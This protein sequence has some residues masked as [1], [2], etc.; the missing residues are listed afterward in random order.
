MPEPSSGGLPTV[1]VVVVN[2]RGVRDTITCLRSLRD[3]LDYP[4]DRLEIICVDNASGDGSVERLRDEMP[5]VTLVESPENLGFAGGCNLGARQ[6]TGQVLA[7]LNNDARPDAE[8]V[9]AAVAVF[10][11][12]PTVGA[13]ASKV[14]D[15][16]GELIDFVDG[17]LTWFG[18]GYKRHAGQRDDGSHEVA[19]DVLFGT[20]SALFVR[21]ELFA[22][23]GGFDE[24][25]FMFYED[26]DLGWRLNLRGWRVRYEPTSVTYHRHH[27]SMGSVDS[28]REYY[29]LER[30]ALA[31]L[32]KNLEDET[33][34][35]VLPAALALAVRRSTARGDIDPTQLEITRR[36][37]DRGADAEPV[38]VS[39][40][41]LAGFLA[42]DQFV[43]LLP[44][45]A[46]SR[47]V[48][49]ESRVRSDGDIVPLMRKALEPAYP[50]PR[51]LAAHETL[52]RAFGLDEAFGRPRR[53]LVVTGDA[54]AERM[55]GPAIRAWHM[56]EALSTEH[57]V[58]LVSVNNH[59]EPPEAGFPVV[60]ARPRDLGTHIAWSDIVVVQGHIMEM[61]PELKDPSSGK[62][63]V[64][65]VYDPMH[66]EYL[67]QGKD[68]DDERRA[69]DLDGVT[70]V[71]NTQ[72]M[73]GDFFLCASE[74]QRHFWLGHL[75][76]LGRLSPGMY[77]SDPTVRSLLS[78]VPFGLPAARPRRTAPAIRDVVP[79]IGQRERIV[80][81]AGGVY[82]WFDPLTLVQAIDKLRREEDGVRLVF[83][84]MQH[85]NPD[86][87]E[88]GMAGQTRQLADRLGLVGSHVFFNETWVPYHERH[89]WLLDAD[90]G[91]TTHFDHVETTF[92]FRTRVLDY[93]WAGL[94]I[95]T[96]DGDSFADLVRRERLGVV[97][98]A[99]DVDALA[100]AL[101][102]VLYDEAFA[103]ACRTRIAEVRERFTWDETLRPL[104]E[105][106]RNPRPAVDRLGGSAPL[107]RE[108][109]RG[110]GG[111]LRHDLGLIRE[112]LDL[113]G[114]GEVARRAAG[115]LR[116]LV[117]ETVRGRR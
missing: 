115:R 53:V 82:S 14:L 35:K 76:S 108:Q 51:Y 30:N 79:G 48:E 91:V 103:E 27:G 41:A 19:R 63:V 117:K 37:A 44:Q 45:L 10:R 73:R 12:E 96:T 3:D 109:P 13:V 70:R 8:W 54:I 100:A 38:P 104:L 28:S 20:G 29:L 50:L 81:W 65:D 113:G 97:V 69:R 99:E 18:M 36:P 39:R 93:L 116:R 57:E 85:P 61:A 7:F 95:I 47:K 16:S 107:V 58:R 49:Q 106:C 1:S 94:P 5:D 17:G 4:A 32:Y 6:A 71:L 24:R 98:P 64:C 60:H 112:Y 80:L 62:I 42:I 2:Y 33:L 26:V 90:C 43:E 11:A 102:R 23:L 52:V 15:W 78:V 59:H 105:F 88:M 31:T 89:N 101:R 87:P 56:A 67:E 21:T 114:P 83:L 74:R 110:A 46:E 55:A 22:A 25:Y 84:G 66:L 68:V 75:A 77:D 9:R 92:A 34:A 86:V 111:Q 72:L 40:E